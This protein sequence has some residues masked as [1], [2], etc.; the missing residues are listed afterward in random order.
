LRQFDES[1][2]ALTIPVNDADREVHT[3]VLAIQKST[4]DVQE[5]PNVLNILN[6]HRSIPLA[7]ARVN[8]AEN[9]FHTVVPADPE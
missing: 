8:F 5:R 2:T 9:I 4:I 7:Q 1:N 6:C 3:I